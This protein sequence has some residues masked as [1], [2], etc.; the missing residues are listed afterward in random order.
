MSIQSQVP[1]Q[2]GSPRGRFRTRSYA[3]LTRC[4]GYPNA[5]AIWRAA[6]ALSLLCPRSSA[7]MY[8]LLTPISLASIPWVSPLDIRRSPRYSSSSGTETKSLISHPNSLAHR[9]RVSMRGWDWPRSH[10]E[11]VVKATP[12]TRA[13]SAPLSL[14]SIRRARSLSGAKP[15]N[16]RLTDGTS[17]EDT[18][19]LVPIR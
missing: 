13:T 15:R 1:S 14:S 8:W 19:P 16:R 4:A 3:S 6:G 12:R 2:A 10:C 5:S 18:M 11:Y 17:R 7:P 9:A